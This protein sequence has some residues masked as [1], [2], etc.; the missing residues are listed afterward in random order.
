MGI[1]NAA[2]ELLIKLRTADYLKPGASVVE[3]GAQQLANSFLDLPER[4]AYLGSLFGINRPPRLSRPQAP[5]EA[6]FDEDWEIL[7]APFAREF[8][9]WLG[10]KYAA[11]DIDGSPRS[12]PIDLN[13][14]SVPENSK[15]KYDLV[16]NFGTTEHVA[17]QLNAFRVIHDLTALDGIMIHEVPTQG[18]MNH[19]LVNY[20]IKFFWMLARSNGYKIVH[21]AFMPAEDTYDLPDN[22]L[23]F[24]NKNGASTQPAALSYK[25]RDAGILVAIQKLADFGFVPPLDVDT[26]MSTDDEQ[27]KQR[28]WSVFDPEALDRLIASASAA[29]RP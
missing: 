15:G 2:L 18:M 10:F 9:R 16:T 13:F 26:G 21:A 7:T 6:D 12:I 29:K 5:A 8:Y 20:N 22:I 3:I 28:Y 17:N 1:G 14:D 19:G 4:I 24:L 25:V 27:L 11:V 23:E